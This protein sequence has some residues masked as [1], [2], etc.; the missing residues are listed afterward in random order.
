MDLDERTEYLI[1]HES[2]VVDEHVHELHEEV[3]VH[4]RLLGQ[5]LAVER[6]GPYGLDDLED[7][8]P[9]RQ[10]NWSADVSEVA[11][12]M[13]EIPYVKLIEKLRVTPSAFRLNIE[14]HERVKKV[15]VGELAAH[16]KI[17]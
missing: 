4:S 10:K 1:Q 16:Q 13:V 8:E 17:P 12:G 9:K 15:P 2:Y 6:I 7:L 5:I 11:Q 14:L 3:C